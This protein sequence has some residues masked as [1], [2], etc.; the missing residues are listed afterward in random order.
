MNGK[1]FENI[2]PNYDFLRQTPSIELSYRI[3]YQ[4]DIDKMK[5]RGLERVLELEIH[6]WLYGTEFY[7]DIYYD[8]IK[9]LITELKKRY[10]GELENG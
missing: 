9:R 1:Y 8:N 5:T 4:E 6:K 3:I 10:D 2:L 7:R